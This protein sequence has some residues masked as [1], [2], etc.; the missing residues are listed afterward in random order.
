MR[1]T[2]DLGQLLL[3]TLLSKKCNSGFG[4]VFNVTAVCKKSHF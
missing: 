4:V 2:F 1:T 3:L